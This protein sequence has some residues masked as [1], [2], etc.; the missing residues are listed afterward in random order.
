[1]NLPWLTSDLHPHALSLEEDA[2]EGSDFADA[3][4]DD[5][6]TMDPPDIIHRFRVVAEPDQQDAALIDNGFAVTRLTHIID[7][8]LDVMDHPALSDALPDG[9]NPH[10]FT[11]K[12]R[13]PWGAWM[14][15]HWR[16]Y[17]VTHA[18][19]PPRRPPRG[20]RRIF[21]GNDLVEAFALRA[22]PQGRVRGFASLRDN[23]ELG[24][25]GGTTDALPHV[26]AACLR[27]ATTLGWVKATLEVD[28]DN[29]DLWAL[30]GAL[31]VQPTQTYV[32]W[33]RERDAARRPN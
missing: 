19:N 32:T 5:L 22:G 8:P 15:S 31:D 14:E 27:R 6:A 2:L 33:Q 24:W 21:V 1:M 17:C 18:S 23:Q 29:R 7:L 10:W 26:L 28:D 13:A 30:T 11:K 9:L 12:E 3:L 16:H 20:L 4:A 25:L